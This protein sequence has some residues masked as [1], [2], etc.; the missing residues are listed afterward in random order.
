LSALRH[1]ALAV[2][3]VMLGCG[4]SVDDPEADVGLEGAQCKVYK[5]TDTVTAAT[6]TYESGFVIVAG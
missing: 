4:G 2:S 6:C 1:L 5:P 3:L